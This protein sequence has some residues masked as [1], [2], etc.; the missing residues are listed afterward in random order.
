V[1]WKLGEAADLGSRPDFTVAGEAGSKAVSDTF[2]SF[3][4]HLAANN[5]DINET[6]CAIGRE[7]SIDPVTE[8]SSDAEANQL[9]GK[10]YRQGYELP[11]A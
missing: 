1:S 4:K 10:E 6:P 2:A 9:F 7:L 11:K 3:E 8:R 5:V